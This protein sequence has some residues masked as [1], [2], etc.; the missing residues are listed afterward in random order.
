MCIPSHPSGARAEPA[1]AGRRPTDRYVGV[2]AQIGARL[3]NAER[4]EAGDYLI[5]VSSWLG[6]RLL[7]LIVP[8]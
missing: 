8:E 3:D 7:D 6:R 1:A 4:N 2:L 5:A